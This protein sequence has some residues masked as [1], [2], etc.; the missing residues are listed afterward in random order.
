MIQ[1]YLNLVAYQLICLS[2]ILTPLR[3][4]HNRISYLQRRQHPGTHLTGESTLGMAADI[5]SAHLY[6]AAFQ[7]LFGHRQQN[8]GRRYNDLQM[9]GL[10]I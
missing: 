7:G 10:H 4:T 2:M 1:Q 3:V 8:E 9:P 5:L 6:P